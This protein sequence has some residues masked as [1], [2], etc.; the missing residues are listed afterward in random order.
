MPFHVEI[1]RSHRR[2]WAFNLDEEKLGRT[3]VRSWRRGRPFVLGDQEWDPRECALTILEG[4][5]LEPS[6]LAHGRGW[7]N[8]ERSARDVTAAVL[9]AAPA[10]R[11]VAVAVLAETAEAERSLGELLAGLGVRVVDWTAV[12][13]H[14]MAA[15]GAAAERPLDVGGVAVLALVQRSDPA[16]TWLFEAGL[17]VGALA[18]SVL[19]VQVGDEAPPSELG[20]LGVFRLDPAQPASVRALAERIRLVSR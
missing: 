8:A 18:G 11:E 16:A 17:A 7:R 19:V 2:A 12:R 3:I 1:R 5:E 15:A 14:L 6:D 9:D 10:L 20:G 13:Q 4:P